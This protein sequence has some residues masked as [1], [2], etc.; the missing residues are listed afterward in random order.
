M[1]GAVILDATARNDTLYQLLGPR[2]HIAVPPPNVR[3]YSNVTLHVARTTSGL[4]KTVS[5]DAKHLRLPRLAKHLSDEIAPGRSVFLCVHKHSAAL[6]E[7][8]STDRLKLNIGYWGAIDGKNTW[9]DCDVT[10]IFGLPYMDQRR[11]INN[12]FATHG[13]QDTTW[14]QANT[15]KQ[16]VNLGRFTQGRK[17]R[18][19][20][21]LA[22]HP[23]QR[24][25]DTEAIIDKLLSRSIS[26][27]S[28]SAV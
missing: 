1:P 12:L 23:G 11:A 7:T 21:A 9:Q 10:V 5:D 20:G 2:V 4:G 25:S 28:T 15:R 6:A 19:S 13:P 18:N 22:C 27:A 24:C 16:Q 14:Q 3:D 26:K 17:V 8:F